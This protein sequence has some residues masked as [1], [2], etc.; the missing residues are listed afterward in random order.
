VAQDPAALVLDM[1]SETIDA[2]NTRH[3]GDQTVIDHLARALGAEAA[4]SVFVDPDYPAE[5]V[6]SFPSAEV[7]QPLLLHILRRG[8]AAFQ[9][10]VSIED[11][12]ELGQV[13]FVVIKPVDDAAPIE[14]FGRILA[15]AR[16]R[17]FDAEDRNLLERACRPL[18][19][20]WPQ[21]AQ[22]A[23]QQFAADGDYSMTSRELQVLALLADGLLATSIAARLSLSPRTVHKHL[24]N[25]YRKLGVHDRLVAV[26]IARARGLLGPA[27]VKGPTTIRLRDLEVS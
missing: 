8:A 4:V 12:P 18:A 17:S 2:I 6:A 14:G 5:A 27:P 11:H 26:G 23:A 16:H 25:I 20:L 22:A 3:S 7:A 9:R 15:F 21:A 24:G 10:H 19:A 1:L 13:V